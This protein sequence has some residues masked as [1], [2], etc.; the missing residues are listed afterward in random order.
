MRVTDLM[1]TDLKTVAPD[2][3]VSDAVVALA[4]GHVSALPVVDARG[5]LMGVLSTTDI[6]TAIAESE[7]NEGRA[8]LFTD[9]TV[10]ELMTTQPLTVGP[11]ES[12]TEAARQM[13]YLEVH[14]LF[15]TDGAVLVGV[16][17]Q[18]DIVGAVAT[19]RV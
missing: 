5:H 7:G 8:R 1:H 10:R 17:S 13:L 9:T 3:T 18:S 6:L 16:I 12:I 4:D 2:A 19:A 14:R 11:A 15:V